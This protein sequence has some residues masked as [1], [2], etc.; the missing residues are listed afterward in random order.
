M[1]DGRRAPGDQSFRSHQPSQG[2]QRG[3]S[4]GRPPLRFTHAEVVAQLVEYQVGRLSPEANAAI[5]A[6][7]SSCAQCQREG[8]GHAPTEQRRARRAFKQVRGGKSWFTSRGRLIILVLAVIA[9]A[10]LTVAALTQGGD[11]AA[12]ARLF[13]GA[14]H[15][16]SGSA[17]T[18]PIPSLT[19]QQTFSPS[20]IGTFELALSPDG[21]TLA[22]G[23]II[24]AGQN[25]TQTAL[26]FWDTT[27]GKMVERVN[28][29][30]G[31][32]PQ[33]L[34]WSPDGQTLAAVGQG[35]LV[36]WS[37]AQKVILWSDALPTGQA[38]LVYAAQ[39]GVVLAQPDPNALFGQ[40][41]F[42]QWG[43]GGALGAAPA[44]A[45]GTTGVA[46]LDGPLISPWHTG[47]VHLFVAKAKGASGSAT[48]MVGAE[49][50]DTLGRG[51]ILSW[52]PDGQYL[53]WG[54][55]A[56]PV[57]V[58]AGAGTP[59]AGATTTAT[60]GITP[61]DLVVAAVAQRLLQVAQAATPTPQSDLPDASLWFSPSAT[62]VAAC[63]RSGRPASAATSL[64]VYAATGAAVAQ[65]TGDCDS[66][67]DDAL[68]WTANGQAIYYIS[69]QR[70]VTLYRLP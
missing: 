69:Q 52:S 53:V 54:R 43:T 3:R 17:S 59:S 20:A 41:A 2:R 66:Q 29:A 16:G 58:P 27:T 45:A 38:M 47:S 11:G 28:L 48:V 49:S 7:I 56:L 33:A 23:Q 60:T 50:S 25:G 32:A 19:Q 21:R 68:A 30:N 31:G 44:G 1:G 40:T 70:A 51:D 55:V 9:I 65:R 64:T 15:A 8:L 6:H 39:S 61:P 12:L 18:T 22:A 36:I 5:E 4:G 46:T 67:D 26:T 24:G 10:Q 14:H 37:F 34:A 35:T 13:S 42:A 63:E 57:A 62:D